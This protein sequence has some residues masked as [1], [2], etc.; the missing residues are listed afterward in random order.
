MSCDWQIYDI[1]DT[2]WQME[3]VMVKNKEV[4]YKFHL[5]PQNGK[6]HYL[7]TIP[8]AIRHRVRRVTPS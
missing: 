4:T 6:S 3:A 1:I 2:K 8:E 7:L 5:R